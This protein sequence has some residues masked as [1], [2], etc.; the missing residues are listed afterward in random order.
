MMWVMKI[1]KELLRGVSTSD[2]PELPIKV[3]VV[4]AVRNGAIVGVVAGLSSGRVEDGITG[5][6]LGVATDFVFR[7]S[8]ARGAKMMKEGR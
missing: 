1:L 7:P 4:K 5:L 8:F 2:L 3:R 6:V